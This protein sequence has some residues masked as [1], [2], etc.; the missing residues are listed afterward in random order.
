T[1][2][3]RG[4]PLLIDPGTA[5]YTID[6]ALRDRMR[7]TAMHN[8]VVIDGRPQSIPRG[9]FHWS[10][11]ANAQV[12][13]WR[14]N[15]AFDYFDGSHDGYAP[16]VHRRRVLALH[17]DLV[18]VADLVSGE[19]TYTAAAHWHVDPRWTVETDGRSVVFGRAGERVG[20]TVPQGL[21]ER[22]AG[23]AET[24]L[25]WYSPA[26]GRLDHTS[27]IRVSH[28]GAAPFWLVSVF[29]LNANNPVA[30]VEWAAVWAEAGAA[31]HAVAIRI[32]RTD[33]VDYALFAEPDRARLTGENADYAENKWRSSIS[34]PSA[35][36]QP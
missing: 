5:C 18:I 22:F 7:S 31:A 33:S 16:L 6:P 10:H 27:T 11:V 35:V 36:K 25:G 15:E 4:F 14:T 1:L 23:D 2:G 3:V 34:A 28:A 12:A 20:L 13:A 19:G 9:P 24:G 8:T 21:V 32:T 30:D 26:Y 29:D 17:A